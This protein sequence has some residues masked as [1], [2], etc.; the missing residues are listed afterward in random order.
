[1]RYLDAMLSLDRLRAAVTSA[2]LA[3]WLLQPASAQSEAKRARAARLEA[4][5]EEMAAIVE[6][7][8]QLKFRERPKVRAA[9]HKE[10]RALVQEEMELETGREVFEASVSTLGL[11]L[12]EQ[13]EVVL[14]PLVVAPLIKELPEDAPRHTREA[15]MH[16]KATVAHELVHALQEQHF[17]LPSKLRA[18]EEVEDILRYKWLIEGHAVLVEER[19]AEGA[20]GLED[21]ML[22][23]PYGGLAVGVDPSYVQGRKYFLHLLR[24][25]GMK[26]VRASLEQPPTFAQMKELT[27]KPLPPA[28]AAPE[29]APP[30][31]TKPKKQ[32]Q[33]P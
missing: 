12:P 18:A 10:W 13:R 27:K 15:V 25:G 22:K 7:H 30:K 17:G 4:A 21:F 5:V 8:A 16:Q 9:T 1:M 19:I 32:K 11:Y 24:T 29:Q 31:P 3:V 2:A 26:A 33:N 20:L 6:K 14:S 28:P 23:G